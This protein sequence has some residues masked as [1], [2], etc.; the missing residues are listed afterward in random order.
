VI[1]MRDIHAAA[2]ADGARYGCTHMRRDAANFMLLLLPPRLLMLLLLS[3]L[4]LLCATH[5][6]RK[7]AK[8]MVGPLKGSSS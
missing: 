2:A 6:R 1:N 4:L 5:M 8:F 7:A 3:L